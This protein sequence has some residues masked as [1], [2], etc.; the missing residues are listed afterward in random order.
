[1]IELQTQSVSA[2]HLEEFTEDPVTILRVCA[3][4][5]YNPEGVVRVSLILVREGLTD[6]DC[7]RKATESLARAKNDA[8]DTTLELF[9]GS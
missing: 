2:H 4:F 1:M 8:L 9:G 5:G 7:I 6:D 3:V